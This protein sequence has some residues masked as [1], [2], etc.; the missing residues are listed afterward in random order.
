MTNYQYYKKK[1]KG[2]CVRCWNLPAADFTSFCTPCAEFR[3]TAAKS[4]RDERRANG[5]CTTCGNPREDLSFTMCERC[6]ERQ[7]LKSREYRG[8]YKEGL[9][10]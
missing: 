4:R 3:R 6:R 9:K 1:Y 2:R 8:K 10:K 5:L 7:K